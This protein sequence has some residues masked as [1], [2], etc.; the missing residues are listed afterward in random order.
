MG[1]GGG[2][3]DNNDPWYVVEKD[4]KKNKLIVCQGKDNPSLYSSKI[5][6]TQLHWIT[7]IIPNEKQELAAKIR[8]R[9]KDQ[10]CT[11][12]LIKNKSAIVS[13]NKPIFAAAAGQSIVFYKNEECLGGGIIEPYVN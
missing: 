13:F 4:M 5:I 10:A 3:S 1:I 8:Y 9:Q 11:V 2:Y 7:N 6:V 12:E